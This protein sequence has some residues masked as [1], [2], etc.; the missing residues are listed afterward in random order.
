MYDDIHLAKDIFN[1]VEAVNMAIGLEYY[2]LH[3]A[4]IKKAY[5]YYKDNYDFTGEESQEY[6]VK[7]YLDS[8][9]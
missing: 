8:L 3:Q 1:K 9:N 5:D 4:F 7:I 6:I 2:D